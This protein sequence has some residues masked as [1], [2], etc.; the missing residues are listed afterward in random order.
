[1]R[2]SSGKLLS[3]TFLMFRRI[4]H[5]ELHYNRRYK[6]VGV[7]EYY[8]IYIGKIWTENQCYLQFNHCRV[9]DGKTSNTKYFLPCREYYTFV[10]Q[11]ARIQSDMERR[12][13]NLIVR[14]LIGDDY[15]EW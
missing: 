1:M 7:H 9:L 13:V 8:G 6:I 2:V 11:K 15:F 14:G 5:N 10:S 4:T 3:I 12:A